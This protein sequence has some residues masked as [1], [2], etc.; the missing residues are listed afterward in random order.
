[1]AL[2]LGQAC[3]LSSDCC[4]DFS[5]QHKSSCQWHS[6]CSSLEFHPFCVY[7]LIIRQKL[8][9]FQSEKSLYL[10]QLWPRWQ[11]L[12]IYFKFMHVKPNINTT[13]HTNNEFVCLYFL[14]F[15]FW[16]PSPTIFPTDTSRISFIT[17]LA[18]VS[19]LFIELIS[20][21]N[22][23]NN[24]ILDMLSV[25]YYFWKKTKQKKTHLYNTG[26]IYFT[27]VGAHKYGNN[28]WR[29]GEL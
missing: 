25:T 19:G 13:A 28:Y 15:A 1:M 24:Y 23:F 10:G 5:I 2:S 18:V 21:T 27:L 29:C 16:T 20:L 14:T 3:R 17:I 8:H 7:L 6:N 12:R 26:H 4:K 9:C 11:P 22:V